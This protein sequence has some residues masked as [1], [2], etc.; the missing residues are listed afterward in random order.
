M[1]EDSKV[2][3]LTNEVIRR[4]LTTS[5]STPQEERNRI[6]DE[7]AQKMANSGYG[8]KQTRRVI[9]SGIKGYEKMTRLERKGIRMVHRTAGESSKTRATKKLTEKSEWFRNQKDKDQEMD[10]EEEAEKCLNKYLKDGNCQEAGNISLQTRTVLFVEQTR[11]GEL[12]KRLRSIGKRTENM[13]GFKTKIVEGVGSKLKNLLPNSNPWK[14]AG[15][16]REGCIPCAQPGEKKQDCRK[17]NIVYESKCVLCNPEGGKYQKDGKDLEDKRDNPSIYVGESGRSLYERSK[18]HWADFEAKAEDSHILKHWVTHHG[19]QGK[20]DFKLEV[21]KYCRDTL[22]RQ[23]G[24]AIWI[25]CRGNT[26]N[27]KAGYNRSGLSR[28][29][30]PEKEEWQENRN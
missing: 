1:A 12:A 13:M 14:G 8:L 5:K 3:S 25:Q 15:C 7:M 16:S 4:M 18:E 28:L 19:G 21:V 17:R 26:L 11:G 6:L 27:S 10:T 2:G 29:V 22:T 30:L 9:L 23:V 20:P 24:E